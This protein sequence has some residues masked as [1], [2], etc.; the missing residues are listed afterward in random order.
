[1]NNYP[2]KERSKSEVDQYE[3]IVMKR[4]IEIAELDV[5]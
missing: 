3:R 1:M 5:S 2:L 4:K